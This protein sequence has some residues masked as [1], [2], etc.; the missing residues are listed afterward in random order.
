MNQNRIF[1]HITRN[2]L[3]RLTLNEE[4]SRVTAIKRDV[5]RPAFIRNGFDEANIDTDKLYNNLRWFLELRKNSDLP[6]IKF[7]APIAY[8]DDVKFGI[9]D[10]KEHEQDKLSEIA[11]FLKDNN[12]VFNEIKDKVTSFKDL[13]KEVEPYIQKR[14]QQEREELSKSNF[15]SSSEYDILED[16]DYETAN[17]YGNM[18]CSK[19]PLCYTQTETVWNKYKNNG[20]NKCYILLRKG[21]KD[22]KE[23]H[24]YPLYDF[25]PY[26]AYDKYGLSMI[27][28]F[29]KPNNEIRWCNT[30]W[31]HEAVFG[32]SRTVDNALN[33][34]DLYKITGKTFSGYTEEEGVLNVTFENAQELLDKGHKPEKMFDSV[35]HLEEDCILVTLDYKYNYIDSEGKI[36]SK[37]WFERASFFKEGFAIVKLDDEWNY[38]DTKF[39]YLSDQWFEEVNFF[40]DGISK[41]K[42]NGKYN[43]IKTNGEYLCDRWFDMVYEF[44]EGFAEVVSRYKYNFINTEGK[45]LLKKWLDSPPSFNDGIAKVESNDKYNFLNSERKLISK[46]WFDE[47]DYFHRG[48]ARVKL[49]GEWL[50]IDREG[51]IAE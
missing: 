7:I 10:S 29:V 28:V 30:R 36:V 5:I 50:Y 12:D 19:E 24:T 16:V 18:S 38:I 1:E 2:V 41:F 25:L 44:H 45:L 4:D 32:K 49:N 15:S 21:W 3:K 34:S 17:Y 37:K 6:L 20:K 40:N 48:F 42:L 14:K 35:S 8:S 23:V 27:F 26:N 39:N 22:V 13:C 33:A 43:F 51:N 31:N 47:A 11:R 9:D 46:Q